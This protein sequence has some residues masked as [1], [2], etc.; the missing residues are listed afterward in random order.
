MRIY[1]LASFPTLSLHDPAPLNLEEFFHRCAAHL[2][3]S[4]LSELDAICS[5]PPGGSSTF[6]KHWATAWTV[7]DTVNRRERLQRL[8]RTAGDTLPALPGEEDQLRKEAL[9][10]WEES[11]PLRRETALLQ[12]QWNWI[13]D[14]R[15]KAPYSLTD[16][17]GYALQLRL[18]ERRD[19]WD[20]PA[21]RT[22][23]NE[24]T[25]SFL[26]PLLEK[27]RQQDLSA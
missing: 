17:C 21:G 20:E 15:R 8:P 10:A 25:A 12:A 22:Q 14:R 2:S 16:L 4:D 24:H 5:T 3:E 1:L 11:D 13:D 23:F 19:S 6:A 18:L 27:L 7:L 9:D 26:A